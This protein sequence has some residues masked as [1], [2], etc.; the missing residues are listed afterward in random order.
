[1]LDGV[2]ALDEPRPGDLD[3]EPVPDEGEQGPA[4]AKTGP[5]LNSILALVF[6]LVGLRIGLSPLHDNSFLTHLATGRIILDT[7]HI[8]RSD[9][10][11]WSA[12]GAAW[13][14]QSWGASVIFAGAEKIAGLVGIRIVVTICCVA[15]TQLV[16]RLTKPTGNLLGR[17]LVA[18]PVIAVGTAYWVERPFLFSLIFLMAVLFALEDR[19]DPRWLVPIMWLWVNVHGSFPLAFVAI[20][21]FLLGRLLDRE[22][23]TVELRVL[24][25]A[26]IGTAVGAVAS[27]IG[28]DLIT[29]PAKLLQHSEAFDHTA[30]WESPSLSASATW[31]YL[32]QLILAVGLVAFR[33]RRW[34]AILPVVVFGALSLQASR[35]IAQ[36]SLVLIVPMAFAAVG[37]GEIRGDEPRRILRPVQI[38]LVALFVLIAVVGIFGQPDTDLG[39]YPEDPVTWMHEEGML[40]PDSRVVT[41]DFVGN[42]LEARYGPDVKVFFDDRV[43]MYPMPV[44]DQYMELIDANTEPGPVLD[45]VDATAVLWDTDS[46]FGDWLEDPANGWKIVH[47]EDDWIVA[48]PASAP[49]G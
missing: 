36:A 37:I 31:M 9:P 48:V 26:G 17:L 47:R 27:P 4:A 8:P 28:W 39:K 42:Y 18:V 40:G 19:F 35:N 22:R 3:P 30:E 12:P 14:V 6:A 25:W 11:S 46:P 2:E 20:G 49:N 7:G 34:R 10:Y 23:P 13:T 15:L 33:G 43:D 1:M 44:V 5:S 41:R 21:C 38:A 24:M 32:F 45:D 16:W 29:F